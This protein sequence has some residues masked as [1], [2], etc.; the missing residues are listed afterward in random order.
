MQTQGDDVFVPEPRRSATVAEAA[1]AAEEAPIA[2]AEAAA[3]VA[4]PAP[5]AAAEEAAPVAEPAAAA[6]EGWACATC[7]L[8]NTMLVRTCD[9]CGGAKPDRQ[10]MQLAALQDGHLTEMLE[11]I[12]EFDDYLGH[13]DDGPAA[14]Q[15]GALPCLLRVS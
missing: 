12:A 2:A 14:R 10:N 4:E 8:V 5:V 6:A 3:P 11:E 13:D 15:T 1:P 7:T 9:A